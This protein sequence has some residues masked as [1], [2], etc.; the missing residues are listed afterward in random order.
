MLSDE[1][2]IERVSAAMSTEVSDLD[3]PGDLL[4]RLQ[5]GSTS[6]ASAGWRLSRVGGAAAVLASVAVVVI[7]VIV[8]GTIGQDRAH[9][10]R[11]SVAPAGASARAIVSR[12]AVMRR[13]QTAADRL[14]PSALD[15]L[16][17]DQDV[18]VRAGLTRLVATVSSGYRSLPRPVRLYLVVE[19]PRTGQRS[20]SARAHGADTVSVVAAFE[21][22]VATNRWLVMPFSPPFL[23]PGVAAVPG[24]S[25]ASAV[26]SPRDVGRDGFRAITSVVPDGVARVRWVFSGYDGISAH[27][28]P[29]VTV[30]PRVANNVAVA[31]A[32]NSEGYLAS[33][34][35]Y[36]ANGNVIA[37]F[38]DNNRIIGQHRA[39]EQ[40]IARSARN[41][42]APGLAAD[43]SVF[44]NPVPSPA[45]VKEPPVRAAVEIVDHNP[46]GLNV[47]RARLVPQRSGQTLFAVPGRHGFSVVFEW[48]AQA[49]GPVAGSHSALSDGL[50]VVLRSGR[51]TET[52]GGL[53]PNGNRTVTVVV[54]GGRRWTSRVVDNAYQ[55]LVT[56][57]ITN[58]IERNAA[59][60]RI[61][62][63]A[64]AE[65][66]CTRGECG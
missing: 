27:P 18:V 50:M 10:S 21:A 34:T 23:A 58:V 4:E 42:I 9:R 53:V 49:S 28:G 30:Y 33:A 7:A 3:P 15:E 51:R 66:P 46:Y 6:D 22:G 37:S 64:P 2:L 52:I 31:E 55:I 41:P 14:P 61:S 8:I 56:G 48:Y 11:S 47:A 59:G 5:A 17:Q 25:G 29:P 35:W 24:G 19:A 57:R 62:V 43:Y 16:E 54:G 26:G 13:P 65:P 60:Q 40:V 1:Q 38:S 44:A 45:F 20:G 12:L 39:A 63:R 32:E 36:G